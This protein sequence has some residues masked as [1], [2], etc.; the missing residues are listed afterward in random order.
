VPNQSSFPAAIY[1]ETVLAVN[2]GD[3]QRHFL[4]ALLDIQYAHTVML[5]R[6]EIIPP[7]VARCCIKGLDGLD[8]AALAAAP[9]DGTPEDLFF[10]VE[11]EL[12]RASGAD[13]AGQMH[14]ARSRNDIDITMYR[15]TLR[16]GILDLVRALGAAR[17]TLLTLARAH[18]H[19]LMPA[20]TH[21]QPAQP[22]T[23]A[24][25]LSAVVELLGRDER[26][27]QAAYATVNRSPMGACAISTTGFPIDRQ[28]MAELLGFDAVQLNSYGA[29]AAA[30]YLTETA[31]V[32]A[33][34]MINIGRVTQDLLAWCTAE[35]GYLRLSDAWVQISSIMPQKRNPVPLEHVRVLA[36]KALAQAGGVL[37]A[38]HNT[39]FGDINDA[40]DDLQPLMISAM[41]DALRAVRLVDG[42]MADCEVNVARMAERANADFLSVTE[43]ADTL[44][45][46]DAMSFGEAHRLVS[47]GVRDLGGSYTPEAMVEAVMALA[48]AMIGRVLRTPRA[49]LLQA[50]DPRH[51]VDVRSIVG[52]PAPSMVEPALDDAARDMASTAAWLNDRAARLDAYPA[53]IRQACDSIL[54]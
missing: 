51:F 37:T 35:F 15:M 32:V 10:F 53:A 2:F 49:E 6:Q 16:R 27:L 9:Y 14:T 3:A 1:A 25:Y 7:A 11:K 42:V 33:T 41:H 5:A 4:G 29:I 24:H 28:L 36:S 19:T 40:E 30:D 31:G 8:R 13:N 44:V 23:F 34:A 54:S 50:L 18:V 52:G 39:P 12:A 48:P 21:T 22:I 46:R 38:L 26:R 17:S 43:L 47:A 45:R 20:Y